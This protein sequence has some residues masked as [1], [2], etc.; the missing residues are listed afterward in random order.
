MT[1]R[2][3]IP[4]RGLGRGGGTALTA[5]LAAAVTTLLLP[6]TG[7]AGPQAA[8]AN[9]T[10][11]EI[12]GIAAKGQTLT[13]DS[14]SWTGSTPMT[15]AYQWK[16]CDDDDADDCGDVS[17]ARG[18]AYAL[19]SGDVGKRIRVSV[20]ASNADGS[21]SE[22]SDATAVVTETPVNRVEPRISGTPTEGQQLTATNGTWVGVEPMTFTYQWVRCG[23]DGGDPLGS[24]CAAISGAT[25]STYTP[26]A[27][28]VGSRLRVRVTAKNSAGGTT[29]A[30][31]ATAVVAA[32]K[33]PANTRRPGIAGSM[34]E[35]ATVTLDRGAWTGAS[36]FTFQWLRCNAAGGACVAIAGAT[37]T[38]YRLTAADVGH[39]VRA[40]VTARNSRGPAT[41]M[42]VESAI[43][44]PAG[45]AGVV[46][47]PSG[48]RSIPATSVATTERLV[49]SEVR[50]SPNPI[51]SRRAPINVRVRVKDTRGFIVRDALVFVR[52][53]PL[54]TRGQP[55]RVR[56]ATDGWA[57]FTMVPRFNFPRPRNGF[58]VQY[59]VKA[60]RAGDHPLAGV[61]G[62]R[63]VQVRLAR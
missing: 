7:A 29:D 10:K 12:S 21:A 17:G 18:Q 45:P 60:Y 34:V 28:D 3:H 62:Y 33:A 50:F 43:V 46:L 40:N 61:A 53:T 36:S 31:N 5:V 6:V 23:A 52:S 38:Q 30:S 26:V 9:Q 35:G 25:K 54:V 13:T 15:F 48:E 44:V 8:P 39:K 19:D 11:P 22:L 14:G 16:R 1:S 32:G 55:S 24:K 37:G 49:V 42:S 47:L 41:V 59:F 57:S 58:N 20:T 51:T 27:A 2:R 63:L 56:T 4:T